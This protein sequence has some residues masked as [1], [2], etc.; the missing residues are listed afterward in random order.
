MPA[1]GTCEAQFKRGRG[2]RNVGERRAA[3]IVPKNLDEM[4]ILRKREVPRDLARSWLDL[5]LD[6]ERAETAVEVSSLR[7]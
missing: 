2:N 6:D 1:N 3:Q 4:S 7:I 5:G